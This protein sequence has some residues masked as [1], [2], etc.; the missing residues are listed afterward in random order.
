[1][2]LVGRPTEKALRFTAR[3]QQE[4][5]RLELFDVESILQIPFF[6]FASLSHSCFCSPLPTCFVENQSDLDMEGGKS[7]DGFPV[8]VDPKLRGSKT[9]SSNSLRKRRFFRLPSLSLF[10][11]DHARSST[12]TLKRRSPLLAATSAKLQSNAS[13]ALNIVSRHAAA[14]ERTRTDT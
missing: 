3:S 11:P 14:P 1:M 12:N 7:R 8:E 6:G 13:E 5:I 10:L 2:N 4:G 9:N